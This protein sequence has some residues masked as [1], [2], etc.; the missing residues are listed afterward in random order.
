MDRHLFAVRRCLRYL[1]RDVALLIAYVPKNWRRRYAM[2]LKF[3]ELKT[4]R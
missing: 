4:G 3:H 1:A 2:F